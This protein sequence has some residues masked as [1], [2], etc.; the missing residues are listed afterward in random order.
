MAIQSVILRSSLPPLTISLVD[1][2]L[3]STTSVDYGETT[4]SKVSMESQ[5]D[6]PL[7][8]S[9]SLSNIGVSTCRHDDSSSV[10]ATAYSYID[11]LMRTHII[12]DMNSIHMSCDTSKSLTSASSESTLVI[13]SILKQ[14]FTKVTSDTPSAIMYSSQVDAPWHLGMSV[15]YVSEEDEK[16]WSMQKYSVADGNVRER[17]SNR[18]KTNTVMYST[19]DLVIVPNIIVS[20]NPQ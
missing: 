14:T 2:C 20:I 5:F 8:T 3:T 13:R 16:R 1:C 18:D 4:T 9:V 19:T 7:T 10:I 12:D 6:F 17:L 15:K 11:H